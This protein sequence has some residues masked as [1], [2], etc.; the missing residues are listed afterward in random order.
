MTFYKLFTFIYTKKC[1]HYLFN[2]S[3]LNISLQSKI[4]KQIVNN[5]NNNNNNICINNNCNTFKLFFI[6]VIFSSHLSCLFFSLKIIGL[7]NYIYPQSRHSVG[8][9][10]CDMIASQFS[11]SW[12]Y[13]HVYKAYT[14]QF[15]YLTK[16]ILLIKSKYPMNMNGK[17]VK[18]I[19]E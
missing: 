1:V 12:K 11:L 6:W 2:I 14:A 18:G 9:S 10:I 3:F 15:L 7:G 8:M 13:S 16:D 17:S 4:L 5:N 19:G